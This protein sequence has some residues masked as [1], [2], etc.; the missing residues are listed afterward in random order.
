MSYLCYMPVA[1]NVQP[2]AR[3]V[4]MHLRMHNY[5]HSYACVYLFFFYLLLLFA[6]CIE[7]EFIFCLWNV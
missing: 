3:N 2:V 6:S 5:S 7:S 1:A 4:C